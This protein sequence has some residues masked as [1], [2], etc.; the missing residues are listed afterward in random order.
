[1]FVC[2]VPLSQPNSRDLLYVKCLCVLLSQPIVEI[3]YMLNVFMCCY[4][5]PIVEIC[6]MLNVCVCFPLSQ[7]NSRDLSSVTEGLFIFTALHILLN[8]VRPFTKKNLYGPSFL[9]F[10]V[11]PGHMAMLIFSSALQILLVSLRPVIHILLLSLRPFI[12][13]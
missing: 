6:Y 13:C 5:N 7:P 11:G 1:M 2:V 4:L 8:L 12:F 10:L 3:C 9:F